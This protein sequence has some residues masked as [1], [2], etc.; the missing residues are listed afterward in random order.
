M[1][2]KKLAATLKEHEGKVVVGGRHRAYKDTKGILTLG[3]GRNIEDSGISEGEAEILLCN[4]IADREA[5]LRHLIPFWFALSENRQR[6]LCE[7][8]FQLGVQG[9][10]G[11][12]N[13][14]SACANQDWQKAEKEGLDSLWA[15]SDSPA[16]AKGL[17]KALRED[18][19]PS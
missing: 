9:L 14:L 11:F 16:R 5:K 8:A 7:M 19:D 17:M 3:Y 18:G 12:K 15:R 2:Y 13:F 6:I 1:D 10:L 4:D